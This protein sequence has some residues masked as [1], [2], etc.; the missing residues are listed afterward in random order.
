MERQI[1]EIMWMTLV[2]LDGNAKDTGAARQMPDEDVGDV[3]VLSNG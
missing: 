1:R 3:L 2:A